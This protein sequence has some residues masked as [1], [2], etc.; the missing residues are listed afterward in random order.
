L[1][2]IRLQRHG[3]KKA[4]YY[5]IVAADQRKKRDGRIIEDLGR[6]NPGQNPAMVKLDIERAAYWVR[7]GAQPS[8]TVKRL[9]RK[10][11]VYYRLHLERWN[12]TPEEIEEIISQWK[13]DKKSEAAS[14]TSKEAMRERLKAEE[15]AYQEEMKKKAEEA[16]KKAEEERIAKQKAEEEAKKAAEAAEAEAEAETEE[17]AEEAKA[18]DAEAEVKEDKKE[19]KAEA[20][21][22]ETE[23]KADDA[24]AEVKEEKKEAKAK[25][26]AEAPAEEKADAEEEAQEEKKADS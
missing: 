11:G 1:V 10:E 16:A 7:N 20:K 5:H 21:A 4:P 15:A 12:K 9:L 3:R 8:E 2:R 22:E 13:A 6:Y 24:E 19:A 18:D 17:K 26:E 14:A 23:A 25:A